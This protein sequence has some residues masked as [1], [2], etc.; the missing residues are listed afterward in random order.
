MFNPD[1]IFLFNSFSLKST[2]GKHYLYFEHGTFDFSRFYVVGTFLLGS[3]S[4]HKSMDSLL[5]CATN[6]VVKTIM[7]YTLLTGYG[8]VVYKLILN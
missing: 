3:H 7:T 1:R 5:V 4:G 6:V 2:K 8:A